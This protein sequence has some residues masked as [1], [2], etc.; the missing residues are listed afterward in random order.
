[1]RRAREQ[2]GCSRYSPL[3]NRK[4]S[5]RAPPVAAGLLFLFCA[6]CVGPESDPEFEDESESGRE[7]EHEPDPA[8]DSH[9]PL[10]VDLD[11]DTDPVVSCQ[12]ADTLRI[13][14][15]NVG[16]SSFNDP[17][18]PYWPT[19]EPASDDLTDF[20]YEQANY[21]QDEMELPGQ[22]NVFAFQ[23]IDRNL[24]RTGDVDWAEEFNWMLGFQA[25]P[26]SPC[27]GYDR[28]FA[29][30][31]EYPCRWP[32]SAGEIG[33]M[34]LANAASPEQQ[35]WDLGFNRSAAAMH[36]QEDNIDAWV[37]S[38]H[39]AFCD[40]GNFLSNRV[41]LDN[42][43]AQIEELPDDVTAIV[44]G[45]FNISQYGPD[46]DHPCFGPSLHP[47]QFSYMNAEFAQ[48]KFLR[49]RTQGVDHVFV[50]DP[51]LELRGV[52]TAVTWGH[53]EVGVSSPERV[54]DHAFIQTDLSLTGSGLSPA[55]IPLI[56]ATL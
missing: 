33:N 3:V 36:V 46:E 39:L 29:V 31:Y 28:H 48:L 55:L 25:A 12:S 41:N 9:S 37:V 5:R 54:S 23:E 24:G 19:W 16:H 15:A 1:V 22:A 8:V 40:D 52:S 50:R 13:T 47:S 43:F 34:V 53:V 56:A 35:T 18:P 7:S 42:L 20:L 2:I 51:L 14:T 45:D 4:A 21:L 17:G 6:S 26:G 30:A 27:S 44:T 10:G 32:C 11:G 49:V 38:V